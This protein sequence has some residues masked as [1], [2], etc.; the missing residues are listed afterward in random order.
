LGV[1][2]WFGCIFCAVYHCGYFN[3]RRDYEMSN[4]SAIATVLDAVEQAEIQNTGV[5]SGVLQDARDE[6]ARGVEV[7]PLE[8]KDDWIGSPF[9]YQIHTDNGGSGAPDDPFV[10]YNNFRVFEPFIMNCVGDEFPT[11]EAA[12]AA[13]QSHFE[14]LI[15]GAL[16]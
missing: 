8:W 4:K 13:A 2:L 14:A 3:L 10:E 12:K 6:L 7:K 15:R 1:V 9:P 5:T 16:V 11:L